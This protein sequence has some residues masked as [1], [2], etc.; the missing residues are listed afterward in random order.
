M[1]SMV[2]PIIKIRIEL[3]TYCQNAPRSKKIE[4]IRD[5]TEYAFP[6]FFRR[7]EQVNHLSEPNCDECGAA[8]N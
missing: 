3:K 8:V 1:R 6:K 5:E 2:S 7:R 4:D